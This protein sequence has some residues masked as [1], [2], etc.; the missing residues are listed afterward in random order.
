M[1]KNN[2]D[3]VIVGAGPVG[4]TAALLLKKKGRAV[5]VVEKSSAPVSESRAIWVH[6][7]TLEIWKSLGMSELAIAEGKLV[8]AIE[9]RVRGIRKAE[10]PYDGNG[11][12]DFPHGLML[13]Q[14]RTQTLLV[15]L[16]ELAEIPML[17]GTEVLEID[18]GPDQSV[19]QIESP[20][21]VSLLHASYVVGA[22]GGSSM[23]RHVADIELEGGTYDS[24]FFVADVI[25]ETEINPNR[26]HLNFTGA[27]TVAVL[28][29]PGQ[30][31]FRLVGNLIDQSNESRAAGYGRPLSLDEVRT[32]VRANKLP[33]EIV[34][35]GWTTTYRSH[36]RVAQSFRSGRLLLAGDASHLH[37]PAGGLGM[38][39]GIADA[40]NLAWRLADVLAGAN[41]DTLD[42]YSI[43]RRSAAQGVIRTSDRLFSLQA[44]TRRFFVLM[45]TTRLPQLVRLISRTKIGRHIAF[46]ALSGTRVRYPAPQSPRRKLGKLRA[47]SLLPFTDDLAINATFNSERGR[48]VVISLRESFDRKAQHDV[49]INAVKWIELTSSQATTLTGIKRVQGY[50]WIRPDGYV[51][52]ISGTLDKIAEQIEHAGLARK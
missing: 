17:W 4:L 21:G 35:T 33:M 32:L 28:P 18:N 16:A 12:S 10:L 37:S 3:V 31:R 39:T 27:T 48:H 30:G 50:A 45:R 36:F 47:G 6:P 7:R 52:A 13:E 44:S 15:G 29:L 14:S 23:V 25:A 22:D 11:F 46:F 41:D 40:E 24:S 1:S 8:D 38:N 26:S 49:G 34:E 5:A 19:L 20:T 51:E 43:E 42:R 9:M 2:F